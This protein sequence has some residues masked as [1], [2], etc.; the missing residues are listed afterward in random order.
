V[1][2]ATERKRVERRGYCKRKR[3]REIETKKKETKIQ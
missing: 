3:E 1:R 2:K